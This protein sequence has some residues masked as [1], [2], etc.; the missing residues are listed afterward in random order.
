MRT[1]NAGEA[2]PMVRSHQCKL[3]QQQQRRDAIDLSYG[4]ATG[5]RLA[6]GPAAGLAAELEAGLAAGLAVGLA[7]GPAAGRLAAAGLAAQ[8]GGMT[9]GR[10]FGEQV[11]L[12]H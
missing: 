6:A 10:L 9:V 5:L 11:F 4:L 7:A 8:W 3:Q 2:H 12:G 1:N